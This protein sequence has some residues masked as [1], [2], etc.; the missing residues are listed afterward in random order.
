MNDH[1]YIG[2]DAIIQNDDDKILLI[3]RSET[4]KAYP[5]MWGLVSGMVEWGESVEDALK[6]EVQ[7]EIGQEI[8]DIEYTGKY[9]DAIGRHPTKTVI[10]L[11]H[12]CKLR[13]YNFILEPREVSELVWFLPS[14]I[15]NMNLAFDHKQMLI[16]EK[17]I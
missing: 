5:N 17:I 8:Y 7:E 1:P 15:R 9:Y 16:D 4:S 11:P 3:K 6:R 10:C 14:E 12:R 2:V 13:D